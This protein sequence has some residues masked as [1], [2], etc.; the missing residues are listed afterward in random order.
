MW[1]TF[2]GARS[3]WDPYFDRRTGRPLAGKERAG[4]EEEKKGSDSLEWSEAGAPVTVNK[5]RGPDSGQSKKIGLHAYHTIDHVFYNDGE[6]AVSL[7]RPPT[8]YDRHEDALNSLIPSLAMP[9]D[10]YP[11]IVDFV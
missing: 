5:M 11:V 4:E 1:R 2:E 9:S 8:A 10:H 7:A 3:V 6:R